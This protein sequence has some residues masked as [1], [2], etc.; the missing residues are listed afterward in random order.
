MRII[1]NAFIMAAELASIAAVAWLGYHFP[2]PFA[3]LTVLVSLGLGIW[4]EFARL[5]HEYPF[6]FDRSISGHTL[7]LR[8]VAGLDTLVKALLAG[9]MA[10]LT[11]S[12]TDTDRLYWIAIIFAVVTFAGSSLLR[13]LSIS[14]K[15]RPSRWGYF[16][17]AAPLG[18]LFSLAVS[19]LPR[20]SFADIGFKVLFDLPERPSIAQASEILFILKQKFDELIQTVLAGFMNVEAAQI[21]G[22]LVSVN[23]LSG[24][25][26]A[27]Y[28]VLIAEAVRF[29]EGGWRK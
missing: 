21:L 4:L 19:F 22:A 23:V 1:V 24:F 27:L 14:F 15:A 29:A 5:A 6:Y 26:I 13:R 20:V 12:G 11:F 16:R 17:L 18:L 10:L 25:V 7:I 3:I 9:V 8:A 28:A 2:I